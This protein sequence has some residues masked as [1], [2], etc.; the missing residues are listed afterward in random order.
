MGGMNPMIFYLLVLLAISLLASAIVFLYKQFITEGF[1]IKAKLARKLG[2][3]KAAP[4][5]ADTPAAPPADTPA[6]P[7]KD[8]PADEP[9]PDEDP[10]IDPADRAARAAALKN[11]ANSS[12]PITPNAKKTKDDWISEINT[13]ILNK[14]T[15]MLDVY[16]YLPR[17]MDA[18]VEKTEDLTDQTCQLVRQI[19]S[20]YVGRP[21]AEAQEYI[22]TIKSAEPPDNLNDW[23][24]NDKSEKKYQR[25]M[26]KLEK[27]EER[28]EKKGDNKTAQLK[29]KY[30]RQK[31]QF[32]RKHKNNPMLECFID[33]AGG[34]EDISGANVFRLDRLAPITSFGPPIVSVT[35]LSGNIITGAN[36]EDAL[37]NKHI[38]ENKQ[39][40]TVEVKLLKRISQVNDFTK[41]YEYIG[42]IEKLKR[43]PITTQFS[44]Q[45]VKK[46]LKSVKLTKF[47]N[48]VKQIFG[49]RR[50][51]K[52]TEGFRSRRRSSRQNKPQAPPVNTVYQ[53][54]RYTFPVP[55]TDLQLDDDQKIHLDIL[56]NANILWMKVQTELGPVFDRAEGSYNNLSG[57][58]DKMSNT[59]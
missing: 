5:P 40:V 4:P 30:E 19:E 58:W 8:T 49:L 20:R 9:P 44:M 15:F 36:L 53:N 46:Y 7:P 42:V 28:T 16:T 54:K 56:N 33:G 22:E 1:G 24:Y 18:I 27:E 14:M 26:N 57:Q 34:G 29:K 43:V 3:K 59:S 6:A 35:D 12:R 50:R 25:T 38:Q 11:L 21:K 17:R 48:K 2:K 23:D 10:D 13:F 31:V 45:F 52:N 41:T 47:T 37:K 51:R 55:Y 39:I 32:Q